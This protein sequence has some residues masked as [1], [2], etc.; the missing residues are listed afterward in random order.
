M[1]EKKAYTIVALMMILLATPM[2]GYGATNEKIPLKKA[3]LFPSV[4]TYCYLPGDDSVESWLASHFDV[5]I[6][7]SSSSI[8]PVS[9]LTI[10]FVYG[11]TS[12]QTA[13]NITTDSCTY[14][15][16]TLK[17]W[18]AVHYSDY[19]FSSA[20]EA[21]EDCF[22]HAKIPVTVKFV[23]GDSMQ[24]PAY[25]PANPR[26]SR[27]PLTW[28]KNS[29]WSMNIKSSVYR[30]FWFNYWEPVGATGYDGYMLDGYGYPN[31]QIPST[32]THEFINDSDFNVSLLSFTQNLQ[33]TMSSVIPPSML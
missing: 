15:M 17:I 9:P 16:D 20:A 22:M 7:A 4:R 8:N 27:L 28:Q 30:G 21:L 23:T 32:S 11:L 2:I 12:V 3:P 6:G 10:N 14:T 5:M 31:D 29:D 33:S 25:N 18:C 26:L 13:Y 1:N 19:G 24:V